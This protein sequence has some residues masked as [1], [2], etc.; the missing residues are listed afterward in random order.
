[1]G[2]DIRIKHSS[3]I[4]PSTSQ[5]L[6]SFSTVQAVDTSTSISP[7]AAKTNRPNPHT[8][9]LDAPKSTRT[10]K[11]DAPHATTHPQ[12]V[13]VYERRP[14]LIRMIVEHFL[15][16]RNAKRAS[17]QQASAYE[18]MPQTRGTIEGPGP[19]ERE[20]M[21][22]QVLGQG[23]PESMVELPTYGQVMKQG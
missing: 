2:F 18:P 14:G 3:H 16:S 1:M 21:R 23:S 13:V 4:E 7:C 9:R 12:P 19:L 8:G 17:V 6:K 22:N 10:K 15:Q 5:S 11:L 20:Q